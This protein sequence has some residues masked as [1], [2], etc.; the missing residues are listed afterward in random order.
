[1]GK[2]GKRGATARAGSRRPPESPE[3]F[4]QKNGERV[5]AELLDAEVDFVLQFIVDQ[6]SHSSVTQDALSQLR[7]AQMFRVALL[8]WLEPEEQKL[9]ERFLELDV[10]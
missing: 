2:K 10:D 4:L 7:P 9:R 5:T 6:L 8:R 1:M 3:S